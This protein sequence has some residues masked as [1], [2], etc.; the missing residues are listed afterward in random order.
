MFKYNVQIKKVSGRL[1]ESVLP[2]KSLVVKSKTKKSKSAVLAE[3]SKF[4]KKK[5]GLVIESGDVY[6]TPLNGSRGY[7]VP[8]NIDITLSITQMSA[9]KKKAICTLSSKAP[10]TGQPFVLKNIVLEKQ[11]NMWNDVSK[12]DVG[13]LWKNKVY[14]DAEINM[15]QALYSFLSNI[16]S[17]VP[18]DAE[19]PADYE[20]SFEDVERTVLP[21][22]TKLVNDALKNNG[23]ATITLKSPFTD[24]YINAKNR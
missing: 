4:F 7:V 17:C 21:V 20:V 8:K 14:Y 10:A 23:V 24:D 1:N 3:A 13:K 6:E 5:Y 18:E 16:L 15:P 22:I 12:F 11:G 19:D 9:N 2:S